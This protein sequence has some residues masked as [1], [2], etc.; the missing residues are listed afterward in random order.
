MERTFVAKEVIE[1]AIQIEV[2]GKDFYE[3]LA[4]KSKNS[5]TK[6]IFSYLSEQEKEHIEKFT[7]ILGSIASYEPK[8]AYP[9]EYFSYMNYLAG[10]K[11]FTQKGKGKELAQKVE[12]EKEA[13]EMGIEAEKYSI[14]FYEAMKRLVPENDKKKVEII[15]GEEKDHLKQLE[16]LKEGL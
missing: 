2:N 7:A 11:I 12:D 9:E 5:K 10:D 14:T 16:E 13:I 4:T 1:L 8:E 15:M 6:K 3:A